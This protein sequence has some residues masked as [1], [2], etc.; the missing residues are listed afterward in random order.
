MSDKTIKFLITRQDTPETAPYE[1]EFE[2]EYRANMNV[3]SALMEIRRSPVNAKGEAT[4]PVTWE[5]NCLEEVCGACSMVING[6]PRQACTALV[7]KLEQPI[8]LAP[9][10]TFPVVRDLAVD[11]SRMFDALKRVKAWIPIDG[12][13]DLG[14]GP[15]MPET[16]RQ[17]AYELSKCMTCGVCLE[18]CPNVNSKSDFIGP[19]PLS[20][21]RLFNAHP[22]GEMNKEERLNALMEDGG[23][24][25]CGNSQNCVQSCPKGIPLTTSIAALNRATTFQAFKNFFGS[26]RV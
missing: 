16:K 23:L 2:L 6:K 14:P 11:R 4:T 24:A 13:Y 25:S 9:M 17:W 5:M 18:A 10:K 15:R 26:D 22:T 20:Q 19:A 3:I 8:R 21:V 7:D 1:E 12:T